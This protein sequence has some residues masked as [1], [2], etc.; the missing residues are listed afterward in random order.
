MIK[1][2]LFDIGGV[3]V[4]LDMERSIRAFKEV[5]GYE[6]ITEILDPCH[7]KGIYGDLETGILS[8]DDF[9][10]AIL[11]ESR[12]G[13]RPEDVDRCM[14]ALLAGVSPETAAAVRS[15]YG[16]YPLYLL[17]NN[18]PINMV[19]CHKALDDAGIGGMFDGEFISWEMK[20][21]KPSAEFY[22]EVIRRLGLAPEDTLFI[23]DSASNVEGARAVGIDARLLEP[24]TPL[25][26]LLP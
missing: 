13:S 17:S 1:A 25:S 26:S 11:A 5:L 15:V 2:I 14:W 24:G 9:R 8:A 16:L 19:A 3:L 12:P 7:Q 20:M 21:L 10:S 6:R 22:R 4:G 18:N 23:D